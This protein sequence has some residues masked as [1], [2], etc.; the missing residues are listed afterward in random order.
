MREALHGRRPAAPLVHGRRPT[1][2][3]TGQCDHGTGDDGAGGGWE[4][5][6]ARSP[7]G[8]RRTGRQGGQHDHQEENQRVRPRGRRV[9]PHSPEAKPRRIAERGANEEAGQPPARGMNEKRH[10]AR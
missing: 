7:A 9:Q 8:S 2:E 5:E 4:R 3:E 10:H 6:G 1:R